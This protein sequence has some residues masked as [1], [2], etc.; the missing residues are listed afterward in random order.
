MKALRCMALFV[1]LLDTGVVLAAT[2][3]V[4]TAVL[5]REALAAAPPAIAAGAAVVT[6]DS[7]GR[8]VVLRQG[9]DGWTCIPGHGGPG[10]DP[11]PLPACFDANGMVWLA[12]IDAGRVPDPDK[13]GLS[14]MLEGGSAWS[15]TDP[16][17]DKLQP[18]M[19]TYIRIP[20]HVMILDARTA[21][22]T[23]LPSG[24]ADPDTHK[25]FVMFGGT[26]Y[27]ILIVPVH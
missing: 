14:Y 18:G 5:V 27:A 8:T 4:D 23:G 9:H 2:P 24:Q 13:P 3:R 15:N 25:P 10:A 17:A 20:P 22:A 11:L 6:N 26:Q 12:A 19:K 16:K 21:N 1:G 7:K